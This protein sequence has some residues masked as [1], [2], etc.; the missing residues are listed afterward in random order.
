[1]T[2]DAAT[3]TAIP[4]K[5]IKNQKLKHI[6]IHYDILFRLIYQT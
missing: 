1:M 4:S 5:H 2:N 6:M 3:A